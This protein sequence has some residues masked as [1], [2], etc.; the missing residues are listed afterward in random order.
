MSSLFPQIAPGERLIGIAKLA[1]QGEAV[2]EGHNVEY[3]TLENRSVL[4]RCNSPRMP[5]TWMINPYRG[6][7]FACKYCYARYTHEFME[8]R[9]GV[10]FERKIFVKQHA[11]WLLRQE[12]KKVRASESIAIGTATD[13]YQ[14]AE[15]RFGVTRALLEEMALHSGLEIGLVTKSRLIVR[16]LPVLKKIAENNK[17]SICV[18]V[19]TL[20]ADLARVLEPRAPRPDLRLEAVRMLVDS[21]LR[22]GV[23]CAP[24]LPGITDSPAD[25]ER[26]VKAASRAGAAFVWANPL[27]LK[28]CAEK[29]FMPFLQEKFPHL[30]PVYKARYGA[31][32][33]LP[34]EYGQKISALIKKYCEKYGIHA[35]RRK[36]VAPVIT[37]NS[38]EQLGLFSA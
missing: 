19:T 5:F 7:E 4:T 27:F 9:E 16:D 15:R 32:A 18:T 31:Q 11:A 29:V 25:M 30:V 10:D 6:C 3:I 13:P 1:A 37:R 20:K 8:M 34:E 23:N 38:H 28:P 2:D 33:Y 26:L 36:T 12:L 35:E 14:P 21:G 24:V 17:L 22:A